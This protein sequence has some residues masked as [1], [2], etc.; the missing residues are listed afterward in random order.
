M[1]REGR[2]RGDTTGN[3]LDTQLNFV[4]EMPEEVLKAGYTRV[5]NTIYDRR[6]EQYFARC[7]TL[8]QRLDR[9]RA[10]MPMA[11]P[12]RLPEMLRF[13]GAS[14]R[15]LLS[16]QGPAY[17][18]FLSRVLTRHPAMLREAVTLAAKGYHLRKITEQVTAVDNFKQYLAHALEQLPA[19]IARCAHEG[20][21]RLHAYVHEVIAQIRRQ[22]GTIMKIFGTTLTRRSPRFCVRSTPLCKQYT[23]LCPGVCHNRLV[24]SR[25]EGWEPARG[26]CCRDYR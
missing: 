4:P 17:L 10:P 1:A 19:D 24:C 2:L 9:R 7:W 16:P 14:L 5:L 25:I 22:Y 26:L 21:T 20:H 18:R 15:Q 6:L 11:T 8:V 13:A 23:F 3:N 12:L